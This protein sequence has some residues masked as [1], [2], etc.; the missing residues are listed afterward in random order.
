MK[1]II[2]IDELKIKLKIK[3]KINYENICP[4]CSK[5]A[6]ICYGFLLSYYKCKDGHTWCID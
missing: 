4:K 6:T 1:S 2:N 3:P 5:I